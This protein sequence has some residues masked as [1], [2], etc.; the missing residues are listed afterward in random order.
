[1][2][3]NDYLAF[4]SA[5]GADVLTPAQYAALPARLTGFIA[6]IADPTEL[7]TV[8]RQASVAAAALALIGV[9]AGQDMLDDGDPEAF[10]TG[11]VA[12]L[13]AIIAAYGGGGTGLSDWQVKTANYTAVSGDRLI[14]DTS[15]GPFTITLPADPVLSDEV[16]I[17][18]FFGTNN[19]TVGRNGSLIQD[20][21]GAGAAGDLTLNLDATTLHLVYDGTMWR[22]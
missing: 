17:K 3:E 11:L 20:D 7:N 5:A 14:C 1:M 10:K 8:W 4:A 13:N 15:G 22:V 12:G 6:G 16:W 19:L 2:P 21:T 9:D 18:G